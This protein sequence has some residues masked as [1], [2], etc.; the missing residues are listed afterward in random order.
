MT[1]IIIITIIL[2]RLYFMCGIQLT[3]QSKFYQ[4]YSLKE[5]QC[6]NKLS[7]QIP[8]QNNDLPLQIQPKHLQNIASQ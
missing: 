3:V 7:V 5:I 8:P 2:Q 4:E 1:V 6:I